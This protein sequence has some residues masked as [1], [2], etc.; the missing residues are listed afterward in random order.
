[1]AGY[2]DA[3]AVNSISNGTIRVSMVHNCS[4]IFLML[5]GLYGGTVTTLNNSNLFQITGQKAKK[6]LEDLLPFL[7]L[8]KY[9]V[10]TLLEFQSYKGFM[11]DEVI[12]SKQECISTLKEL[13]KIRRNQ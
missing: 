7:V 3:K 9:E 5:K 13:K 4:D 10:E 12:R 8:K 11:A 6:M 1:M 2:F